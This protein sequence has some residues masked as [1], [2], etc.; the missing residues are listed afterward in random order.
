[1]RLMITGRH[2]AVTPALRHYIETKMRR[3]DRYGVRLTTLQILLGVEKFRHAA[4]AIG[5]FH[6]RRLQAKASTAEM[7]SSIDLV[8]DKL[9]TQI[10]KM[11]EK[12]VSHKTRS[13]VRPMFSVAVSP[14][15]GSGSVEISRP[16]LRELTLDEALAQLDQDA[17]GVL[18]FQDAGSGRVQ[19]VQRLPDGRISLIDPAAQRLRASHARA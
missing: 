13:G 3:L 16:I 5:I 8:V 7:Y 19:V 15:I 10:R 1:M 4:E 9:E 18:V 2:V 11:K 6:G 14:P 17:S 12:I